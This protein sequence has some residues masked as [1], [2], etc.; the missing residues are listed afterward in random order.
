M[1]LIQFQQVIMTLLQ[2]Q[3]VVAAGSSPTKHNDMQNLKMHPFR[4]AL[5]APPSTVYPKTSCRRQ[6]VASLIMPTVADWPTAAPLH[7]HPAAAEALQALL[8]DNC[9][10]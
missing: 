6:R 4:S 10:D 9:P 1:P 5:S 3:A 8:Q 7:I 2:M